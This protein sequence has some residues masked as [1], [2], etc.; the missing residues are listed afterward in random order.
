VREVETP[1]EQGGAPRSKITDADHWSG[2]RRIVQVRPHV[3]SW[4]AARVAGGS[5]LEIGPGLRPTAPVATS[6]FIDAS[7]HALNRL[8][9][10]GGRT[11]PAGDALPFADRSFDAVLAFE[12]VEHVDDD[13]GLLEEVARVS[14]PGGV[15]IL[16]TPIHASMWSPLDDACGHVR[17]DE[18]EVL[19]EKVRA[20]GFEIGGYTWTHAASPRLTRIR[21]LALTSNRRLSTAF[22]QTLIF[23]FH[24]AYQRMFTKL[25]WTSPDVPVP[26][27]GDD[28]MLWATR[29]GDGSPA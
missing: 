9:A 16:S 18:P 6:T 22:V 25:A 24:A 17:R 14:R 10:R 2:S 15:L 4:L 27:E 23:P 19:F 12:V 5:V 28:V 1:E 8:A 3:W 7:A 11:V 13:T 20:A 29:A 26:P 21:A